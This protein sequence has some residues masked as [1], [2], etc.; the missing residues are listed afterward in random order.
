MKAALLIFTAA[1]TATA[2]PLPNIL[3]VLS[4]DHSVPHMGC[5]GDPNVVTPNFDRF[6]AQA[7]RFNRAYT[8]APQCAPSRKSILSG[9]SPVGLQQTLFTLPLQATRTML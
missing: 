2:E 9:R 7:V 8:T 3:F 5:Y 6:A 4:D 1:A